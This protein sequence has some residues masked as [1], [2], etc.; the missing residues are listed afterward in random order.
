MADLARLEEFARE[1]IAEHELWDWSFVWDR[2]QR[3]LGFCSPDKRI[4]ISKP[5]ARLNSDSLMQDTVLHEIA[6]A[7]A[8]VNAGHGPKWRK[9]AR[10]IGAIP[11]TGCKN[12][13]K[14]PAPYKLV[15]NNGH[16][17]PRYRRVKAKNQSCSFCSTRYDPKYK[18]RLVPA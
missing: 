12:A 5:L 15:C 16:E 7:L 17:Y 14:P 8:G 13:V 3:R 1:K 9:I 2:A 18:L 6:H 11:N 4:S 10:S